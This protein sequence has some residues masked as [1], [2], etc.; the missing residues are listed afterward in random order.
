M[1]LAFDR[2]RALF[3]QGVS[4]YDQGRYAE[5]EAPLAQ[6][7]ALLP[8]RV[9]TLVNLGA[10]RLA[11]GRPADALQTLD[12]AVRAEP[13]AVDA[14]VQR[15]TALAALGRLDEAA[16]SL[17][18]FVTAQPGAAAAWSL[19]GHVQKD[20][21]RHAEAREA[22]AQAV[23]HG[24]DHPV[25]RFALAAL[26]GGADVPDHAPH[27]YVAALFDGYAD[28][29]EQHLVNTLRYRGHEAVVQAAT[30][31]APWASAL[32]L[33]C[34]TGLVGAGLR[35]L[36]QRLEGVDLSR[37]MLARARERGVYDALVQ[38][39]IAEHLRSTHERHDLVVAADVFIY[40][41]TLDAVFAGV[42][43]VLAEGGRFVFTVESAAR[44]IELRPSLRYAHGDDEI[45]RLAA[46]HGFQA[47]ESERFV[48]REEQRQPIA[49][50]RVTLRRR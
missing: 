50:T 6:A 33:G 9:S 38:G 19:L 39:D 2:A 17:Q 40:V 3:T 20:R 48:L 36:A 44:G 14:Q 15:A 27:G 22:F 25:N 34:G 28:D 30:A 16:D 49:G 12:Q 4:L 13:A 21:G 18:A 31:A 10:V 1:P 5:A 11:L 32:D 37:T 29:F 43:R 46:A 47:P 35:P 23:A 42:R 26:G 41:G 7:L 24:A 8:G 45:A